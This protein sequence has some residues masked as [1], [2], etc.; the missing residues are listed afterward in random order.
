[1]ADEFAHDDVVD[2]DD[3]GAVSCAIGRCTP[4]LALGAEAGAASRGGEVDNAADAA[5]GGAS[6][7]T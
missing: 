4:P 5:E 1:M 7:A 3:D 2:E 6:A